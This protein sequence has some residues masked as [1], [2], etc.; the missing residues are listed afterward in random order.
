MT[1]EPVI[2]GG[3]QRKVSSGKYQVNMWYNKKQY[4]VGTY[5]TLEEAIIYRDNYRK[6]LQEAT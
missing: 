3:R 4:Y 1:G 6:K 2:D 5:T